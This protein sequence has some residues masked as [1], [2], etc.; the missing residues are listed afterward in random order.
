M[1]AEISISEFKA[2]CLS[3]LDDVDRSGTE[4]VV[5]RRHR[6][7]ARI[8]PVQEP[9]TLRGSVTYSKE[10]DLLSPVDEPWEAER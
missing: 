4:I 6:P 3:L 8:L 9:P 2:K 1:A 5:T 7:L 10:E